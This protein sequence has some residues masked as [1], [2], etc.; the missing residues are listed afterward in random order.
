MSDPKASYVRSLELLSRHESKLLIVDV[1][2]KLV[3]K[4]SALDRLLANCRTL[5]QGQ[6]FSVFR[7]MRQNNIRKDW[8]AP[9]HNSRSCCK[10]PLKSC[11]SVV[12]KPSSGAS[13]RGRPTIG[14]RSSSPAW[15]RMSACY[16]RFL[17]CWGMDFKST[18]R[19]TP[20]RAAVN[21][22]GRLPSIA[23]RPAARQSSR[24]NPSCSNGVKFREL[25]SSS[26]SAS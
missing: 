25:P 6:K 23:C 5:I 22:T 1:Q 15:K 26:R 9:F 16:R 21:S 2:E 11:V 18:F 10:I 7:S 17:I 4:I 14:F 12:L 8:E 19:L 20:S 13:P 3:P 24:P